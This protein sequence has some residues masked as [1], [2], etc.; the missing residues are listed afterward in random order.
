MP[1]LVADEQPAT[2]GGLREG[3]E[4]APQGEGER[5]QRLLVPLADDVKDRGLPVA[6]DDVLVPQSG[7]LLGA[8]AGA[9]AQEK[10]Q[11]VPRRGDGE[12]GVEL[13]GLQVIR[14][15]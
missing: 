8:Q 15:A 3:G 1:A 5:Q 7:R 13:V 2:P 9:G 11:P 6:P 14:E 4:V 10:V 12:Q